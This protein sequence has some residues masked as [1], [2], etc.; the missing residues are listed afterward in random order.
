MSD[1]RPPS[2]PSPGQS[3]TRAKFDT[4]RFRAEQIAPLA[5]FR[6]FV[7]GAN[8]LAVLVILW[9]GAGFVDNTWLTAWTA[10]QVALTATVLRYWSR[11]RNFLTSTRHTLG[12]IEAASLA[13]AV[14]WAFPALQLFPKAPSETQHIIIGVSFIVSVTG[15]FALTRLP[16]ASI[17]FAGVVAA[18]IFVSQARQGDDI[19]LLLGFLAITIAALMS[20]M[21]L[22]LQRT[23]LRRAADNYEMNRQS[24]FISL[25]LKD[26]ES[27]SSDL[28]W[29]TDAES[30]FIYFSDRLPLL[31]GTE[32]NLLIG[33][34]F[35]EAIGA[36]VKD[37][38]W[39]DFLKLTGNHVAIEALRLE[40]KRGTS[41][42]D[43]WMVT[44]QPL[45]GH[46]G[47]FMGY[48]G[49]IRDISLERRTQLDLIKAKEEAE[50]N[51]SAKS[52][53]LAITS[54]ELK[55]PLNAIV[56]F[57]EMLV[58][59]REGP[60]GSPVYVEYA[61]TIMQ[62]STHLRTI[63]ADILDVTRI[64]RGALHLAEQEMDA[65]EIFEI[66]CKMC[67]E[68]AKTADIPLTINLERTAEIQGDITRIRQVLINLITNAIKFSQAGNPVNLDIERRATGGLAFVIQDHG[69]GIAAKD[70]ERM[71]EPFE[72]GDRGASRR[73]GGIG[74]G[75]AIARKI[76][77]MHGGDV[78][79]TSIPGEGT[80]ARF[81]LPAA[82]VKWP[83]VKPPI[84]EVTS[85]A[86]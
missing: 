53:F 63:I 54:H 76:A 11:N 55:T 26:F 15:S 67:R 40:V 60:L 30:K 79:L 56:G 70:M 16:F 47:E 46:G 32:A 84:Q 21:S 25:L 5:Q 49:V 10:G 73:H 29:E 80:I 83:Q 36:S 22:A 66:A 27:C 69:I 28:L 58:A 78:T 62:S 19:E 38:G 59:Q 4:G 86:A 1:L 18:A 34:T 64:E 24:E 61:S 81:S 23:L 68:Q 77:R 8:I 14:L 17:V 65:A 39:D 20:L 44:A 35:Q 75:L 71:F 41:S 6:P 33:K 9:V 13:F 50:R 37:E 48:R 42:S 57:S 72:Q 31:V 43:W 52:Q 85:G 51:S 45:L 82:R 3:G 12:L 7:M 2:G 74:L